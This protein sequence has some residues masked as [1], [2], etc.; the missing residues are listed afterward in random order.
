MRFFIQLALANAGTNQAAI[1]N[2][3]KQL[4]RFALSDA[5]FC[6]STLI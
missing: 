6:N 4:L 2:F 1:L 3:A 5:K